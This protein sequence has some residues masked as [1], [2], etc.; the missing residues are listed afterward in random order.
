M[1]SS[2]NIRHTSHIDLLGNTHWCKGYVNRARSTRRDA[3]P[4]QFGLPP[5]VD[6]RWKDAAR[7]ESVPRLPRD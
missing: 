4:A 5:V 6:D 7:I 1:A 2:G 3:Q